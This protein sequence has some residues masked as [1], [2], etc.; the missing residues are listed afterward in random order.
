MATAGGTSSFD[1][2]VVLAGADGDPAARE[3]A[4]IT[5]LNQANA[6][7]VEQRVKIAEL[8][9][10]LQQVTQKMDQQDQPR[11]HRDRD[12]RTLLSK[13]RGHDKL[14]LFGG[15]RE[16]F[17]EWATKALTFMADEPGLRS[18]MKA[19]AKQVDPIGDIYISTEQARYPEEDINVSWYSEQLHTSLTM[20]TTGTAHKAVLNTDGNGLESWRKLHYLYS[21]VTPQGKREL[22]DRVMH[23]PKAKGYGDVLAV[24]EEWEGL[25]LKYREVVPAGLPQD[26][27]ITSYTHFLPDK[28]SESIRNLNE[29]LGA[30]S[31]RS[32]TT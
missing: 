24:Q 21:A 13:T 12:R 25:Y 17:T 32:R 6:I 26:V 2:G 7:A 23:Y 11:P 15:K 19:A 4:L 16:E 29:D 31:R 3:A 5:I 10:V 9:M 14:P 8:E 28:I 18:V 30:R 20:L 22:L 27:L 1:A